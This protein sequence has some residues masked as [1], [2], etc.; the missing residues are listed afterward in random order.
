[1]GL[2]RNKSSPCSVSGGNATADAANV[3]SKVHP[4]DILETA[5]LAAH[6]GVPKNDDSVSTWSAS[7]PRSTGEGHSR[8]QY[9]DV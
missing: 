1:V 9:L 4:I 7:R 8:N 5:H 2:R 3:M 6:L